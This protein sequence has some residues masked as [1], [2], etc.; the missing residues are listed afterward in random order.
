MATEASLLPLAGSQVPRCYVAFSK[1]HHLCA[2]G[3]P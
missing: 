2:L 3:F 1:S